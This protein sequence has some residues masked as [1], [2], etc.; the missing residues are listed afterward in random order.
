MGR[1]AKT[2]L[3]FLVSFLY[4]IYSHSWRDFERTKTLKRKGGIDLAIDEKELREKVGKNLI[5]FRKRAGF[6]QS[7]IAEIINYS[8]KSVS[9]WERSEGI[10]DFYIL[11]RLAEIYGV[12]LDDFLAEENQKVSFKRKKGA[13][14]SR[15]SKLVIT[16][17][18]VGL[19]WVVATVA[20]YILSLCGINGQFLGL[21]YYCAVPATAI[22]LLV[23]TTMWF[24]K[25]FSGLSASMLV[26]SI[27]VGAHIYNPLD[28][29]VNIYEI[30]VVLQILILLW[31]GFLF[32][33]HR[34]KKKH[35]KEEQEQN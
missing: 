19:V 12:R 6:T 4:N 9:K 3:D 24:G 27:A 22:V 23:F 1:E 13:P 32:L 25:I 35:K 20:H 16:A 15:K 21:V 5:A 29:G 26:W 11:T 18:A 30:A 17:L 2:G 7:E 14:L 8:D 34:D 31:Y 28:A 10:P 33:R